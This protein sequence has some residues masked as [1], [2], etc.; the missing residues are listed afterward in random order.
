M[1]RQQDAVGLTTF[2]TEVRLDMPAGSS[3]RHFDEMMSQLEAV[4]PGRTTDLGATLH[5]LADRFKRRCLIVL[6]SDLYDDPE[7][8]DRALHHFRHK[9][10]E[11]IVFHVLDRAEIEFP[12]RETASFVD[13]ETGERIQVDPAYVRDDYRRQLDGV[14]RP[15]PEDLRGLP[16]RLRADRHLGALR[17][18]AFAVPGET[19]PAMTFAAPLFLLAAIAG[20]IPVVLH[21]IHRQKAKEVRFSTL[22]FLRVSVQRTRRRKYVE[23]MSLLLVRAASPAAHRRRPGPA[24]ALEPGLALGRRAGR[25]DGG[26]PR[27][28]GQHGRDGRGPA[29]V[30]HGPARRRAGPRAAPPRRPG[31][32]L[33][34]LRPARPGAR[35]ALPHP[36]DRAAGARPVPAE[37]R[38]GR[39][40]RQAPA[41]RGLAVAG[42]GRPAREIYVFTDN[43]ALSWEGL[44]EQ[45][46]GDKA[47]K[48]NRTAEP[49][50]ILV[51]VDREPAPN[52]ALQT[53]ALDSPAP[54][55]GA[56]FRASV[57]VLNTAPVPQQRHLELHVDGT[58]E[59]ISPTLSL[60][61]GGMV[62]HEFRF[63]LDRAGVHRGEVRLA[64]DDGSALDN[65]L[66][67]AV[68]V[69]QQVPVAIVKPRQDEVP[70]ADDGFYLERALVP[71]ASGGG[72][73]RVHDPRPRSR[74]RPPTS[75]PRP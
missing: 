4:K 73:F 12:F 27:Q 14:P 70:Q 64:E 75:R 21:L 66:Y 1:M 62:K 9:R 25:G 34:D 37:L 10:H 46:E 47:G 28:L 22:R 49:P 56:P 31:G 2:D 69:D 61:P 44:K 5:R 11:V 58:R 59:A 43:Q 30:R 71:G 65:R 63:V 67:F 42:R 23:D 17:S 13:M 19:D 26:R 35:P 52:V 50:L 55:A 54:V 15:L 60:P 51:N 24:R 48:P 33:A 3:P 8:V 68:T 57:E 18:H 20:L 36:R 45:A 16:V 38:A 32:P 72:A 53:I 6:I 40:R 41:S 74:C 39:P 29:P 7:A